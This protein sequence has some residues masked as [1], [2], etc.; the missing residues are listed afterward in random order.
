MV[1]LIGYD[2]VLCKKKK[3]LRI[4]NQVIIDPTGL[5]VSDRAVNVC[6]VS[7]DALHVLLTHKLNPSLNLLKTC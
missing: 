7:A 6:Q 3:I 4:F 1:Y 5:N 2:T